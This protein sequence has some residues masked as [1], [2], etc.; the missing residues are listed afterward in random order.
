G[1]AAAGD[2]AAAVRA[3]RGRGGGARRPR[4]RGG[5]AHRE[6]ARQRRRRGP[7]GPQGAGELLRGDRAGGGAAGGRPG[8]LRLEGTKA[9]IA[10]ARSMVEQKVVMAL[11]EKKAER[12][13]KHV[14]SE[15]LERKRNETGADAA[16]AGVK[17]LSD[18]VQ[19]WELKNVMARK[20]SRLDAMLQRYLIRHFE[21]QKAEPGALSAGGGALRGRGAR[22]RGLRDHAGRAQRRRGRAAGQRGGG[23]RACTR[24][25][26]GS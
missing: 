3:P 12:M 1:A 16:K 2:G 20:L 17:G 7:G 5:G 14:N 4:G 6:G 8:T 9:Q 15:V 13:Q 19:K 11:G 22:R 25:N 26:E 10:A 24:P 18:F 23:G 21:P